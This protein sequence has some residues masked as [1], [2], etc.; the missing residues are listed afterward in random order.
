MCV[1][2][3]KRDVFGLCVHQSVYG[4]VLVKRVGPC[5]PFTARVVVSEWSI[6]V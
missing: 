2:V 3:E 1:C 4:K 6:L 5:R